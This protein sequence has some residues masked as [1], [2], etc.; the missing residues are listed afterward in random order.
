MCPTNITVSLMR[1]RYNFNAGW[2][3]AWKR[4]L[5]EIKSE[6]DY[7]TIGERFIN[8]WAMMLA[9]YYCLHSIAEE[10]PFSEKEVHDICIEGLK[11]QHS[12]CNSTD[13]IAVFWSM[14]SKARQLGDIREGQDYK[15]C[16]MKT[17][18]VTAKG[19][20]RKVVDFETD[21]YV[22][23]IR[24]KICIAKANIQARRE[25]KV[26]IPDESLLSYLVSTPDYYGKT[27][28]PLKFYILDENG[29]PTRKANDSGSASLV[30]DQ[31]RALAFDYQSIC[32]N[33]DINLVTVSEP[34]KDKFN[35]E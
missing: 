10:L 18:K 31:E 14:F 20:Q 29:K 13:E 22:L 16:L 17:L 8:N 19:K 15:V 1:Y 33:Y 25:G 11:Y 27:N 4:A 12:L 2:F 26:L 32:G 7:S 3:N 28:S 35:N 24:E 23:F 9:T 21:R 5:G 30:F 6:V 34:E